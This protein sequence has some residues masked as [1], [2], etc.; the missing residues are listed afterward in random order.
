VGPK[1]KDPGHG[2]GGGTPPGPGG[3]GGGGLMCLW[4]G[5]KHVKIQIAVFW[6]P[7]GGPQNLGEKKNTQNKQKTGAAK[8]EIRF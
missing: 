7:F 3:G 2:G 4:G 1:K 8:E 5:P 6:G